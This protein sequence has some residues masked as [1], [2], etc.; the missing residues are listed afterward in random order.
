MFFN[1]TI[2]NDFAYNQ[3]LTISG[4]GAGNQ[5][6]NG[7]DRA[8]WNTVQESATKYFTFVE[9]SNNTSYLKF[10]PSTGIVANLG[11]STYESN[12]WIFLDVNG[13]GT[14][15]YQLSDDT[16]YVL[17]TPDDYSSLDS[18]GNITLRFYPNEPAISD[19]GSYPEPPTNEG[20]PND[21]IE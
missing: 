13:G 9:P 2:I 6:I 19:D 16:E 17:V 15:L 20:Q 5:E 4:D 3:I 7:G 8:S 1:I 14:Y 10:G 21:V 11:N 12:S 18:G